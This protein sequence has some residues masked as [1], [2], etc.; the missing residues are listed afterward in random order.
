M[1]DTV[2]SLAILLIMI[3]FVVTCFT[4]QKHLNDFL[5]KSD[6]VEKRYMNEQSK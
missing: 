6:E 2:V 4:R 3:G 5:K 1:I